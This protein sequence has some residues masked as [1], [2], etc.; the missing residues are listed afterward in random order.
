MK[1]FS[2]KA[3][4]AAILTLGLVVAGVAPAQAATGTLS[5]TSFTTS[6]QAPAM[7]AT[8]SAPSG[9]FDQIRINIQKSTPNY[10]YFS[11]KGIC[12]PS[13]PANRTTVLSTCG[14]N[15]VTVGG[16]SQLGTAQAGND[17]SGYLIIFFP[18]P[19]SAGAISID[20]AAGAFS[21][22]SAA[23]NY[24]FNLV[25]RSSTTSPPTILGTYTQ[26]VTLVGA[27]QTVT[28]N[29]NGADGGSMSAQ[30]GNSP[31]ALTLNAFTKTG[32]TFGGWATTQNNANAGTVFK[33][34][35]AS[36]SFASS[37]TLYAIWNAASGG[38]GSNSGSSSS[39]SDS[40]AN[41]GINSATGI[42]LLAG[43]LSLALV[44]AEMFMIARRKR[45]N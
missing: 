31:A 19:L 18:T 37:V 1:N 32:Y 28:F 11:L 7:I 16:V 9:T 5:V 38:G 42:S 2:L 34:D 43:G 41:T 21:T 40:L 23:G 22:P 12:P 8:S 4:G 29:G 24:D 25:A 39:S 36:W 17:G 10:E 20:F 3:L 14:I 35:G 15:D 45:S 44:G 26:T 33:T 27:T 6:T 30:T 13:G